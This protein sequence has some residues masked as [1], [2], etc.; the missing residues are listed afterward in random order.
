M[1]YYALEE[2]PQAQI[3]TTCHS[4][5]HYVNIIMLLTEWSVPNNIFYSTV[6]INQGTNAKNGVCIDL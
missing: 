4:I 1:V 2:T 3:S 5:M 6:M